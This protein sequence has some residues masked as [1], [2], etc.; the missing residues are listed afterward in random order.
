MVFCAV[1]LVGCGTQGTT[2]TSTNPQA[3]KLAQELTRAGWI[4]YG[5]ERCVNC[6][7]QKA[8]FSGSFDAVT[9]VECNDNG[10]Q[11]EVCAVAGIKGYP[12]WL[13]KNTGQKITGLRPLDYLKGLLSG[14]TV[15]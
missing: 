6:K 4:M 7:K 13:N 8:L 2:P 9:Y 10:K 11:S 14:S 12:T 1:A 15:K 5:A 3:E